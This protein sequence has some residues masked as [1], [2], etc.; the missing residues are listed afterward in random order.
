MKE[1]AQEK[2]KMWKWAPHNSQ[3]TRWVG[4]TEEISLCV[5]VQCTMSHLYG[6]TFE[7]PQLLTGLPLPAPLILETGII[8]GYINVH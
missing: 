3:I 2:N 6:V 1:S 4:I 7:S 8:I 5:H